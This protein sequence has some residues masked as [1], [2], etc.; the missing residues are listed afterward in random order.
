MNVAYEFSKVKEGFEKVKTDMEYLGKKIG[1]NYETFMREHYKLSKQVHSLSSEI[2]THL[3]FIKDHHLH[4]QNKNSVSE[5]EIHD[6]KYIV[7]ELR[8]EVENTQKE[9]NKII[10]LIN[11]IKQDRKD[12]GKLKHRLENSELE[13][14]LLKERLNEKDQEMTQVKDISSHLYKLVSDLAQTEIELAK[15]TKK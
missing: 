2:K 6:L 12:I 15:K 1:D 3:E 11:E 9:H 14:Y 7:K 10:D 5:K 4:E 8:E 13:I